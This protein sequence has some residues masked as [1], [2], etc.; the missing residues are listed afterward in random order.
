ME[1]NTLLVHVVSENV[2]EFV[3]VRIFE[4][5]E[6]DLFSV[7]R[8]DPSRQEIE[9]DIRDLLGRDRHIIIVKGNNL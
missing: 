7:I 2:E 9:H 6:G 4:V 8:V 1:A 5:G 3:V